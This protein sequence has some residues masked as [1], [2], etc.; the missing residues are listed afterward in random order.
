MVVIIA[1]TF[2]YYVE[3]KITNKQIQELEEKI[4]NMENTINNLQKK[5]NNISSTIDGKEEVNERQLREILEKYL[6]FCALNSDGTPLLCC[7]DSNQ[8]YG[9]QLYDTY[10]EM[11]AEITES[12]E[13]ITIEGIN[14]PLV[15][16]SISFRR[17]KD[18]L[19]KYVSEELFERQF[20]KY[21]KNINGTLYITHN[22]GEGKGYMIE[23][24]E[25][26][27]N[28][29]N[30]IS[31]QVKCEYYEGEEPGAGEDKNIVVNFKKDHNNNYKIE[32]CDID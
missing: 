2:Y 14:M 1:M 29:N 20:T 4:V 11:Y 22:P 21:C 19:L 3:K 6:S 10:D 18:A 26:I 15:K 27:S 5:S 28:E 16:T 32:S 23:R 31:Y 9:L 30:A 7:Y 24:M 8:T 17:Y 25:L 13:T 12:D